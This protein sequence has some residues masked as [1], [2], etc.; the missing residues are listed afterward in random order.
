[1]QSWVKNSSG[2]CV[3]N[4]VDERPAFCYDE[5]EHNKKN[6]EKYKRKVFS[7]TDWSKSNVMKTDLQRF[8]K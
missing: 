6:V 3:W 5:I 2:R 8:F 1:M 7:E 4:F